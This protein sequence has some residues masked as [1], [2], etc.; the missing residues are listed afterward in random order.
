MSVTPQWA[1][2]GGRLRLPCGRHAKG[3]GCYPR[4][5]ARA[6]AVRAEDAERSGPE[7]V[8]GASLYCH[9]PSGEGVGERKTRAF[10]TQLFGSGWHERQSI[11]AQSLPPTPEARTR[12][13]GPRRSPPRE[14]A[15]PR[16]CPRPP[17]PQPGPAATLS[18][19]GRPCAP[20]SSSARHWSGGGSRAFR[21]QKVM[22]GK[23]KTSYRVL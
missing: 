10:G 11:R 4:D 22:A 19:P 18:P 8:P 7:R 12:A 1:L 16:R 9:S 2:H 17:P 21:P 6:Y 3:G 23:G 5:E 14:A 13:L 15:E 20:S